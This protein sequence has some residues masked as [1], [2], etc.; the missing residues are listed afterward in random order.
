MPVLWGSFFL[1][2]L[3]KLLEDLLPGLLL[4]QGLVGTV[5]FRQAFFDAELRTFFIEA[6]FK[7]LDSE[8][9]M[10]TNTTCP[11]LKATSRSLCGRK[12][13]RSRADLSD[14]SS[15]AWHRG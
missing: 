14:H 10:D 12:A 7:D 1:L 8:C 4:G 5:W 6:L 9:L 13:R 11:T 15:T 2:L 3:Q